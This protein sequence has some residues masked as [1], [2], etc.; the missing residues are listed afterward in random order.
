VNKK[1][2]MENIKKE[3]YLGEEKKKE[4][5][6]IFQKLRKRGLA[7]TLTGLLM[8]GG[9]AA[10]SVEAMMGQLKTDGIVE[11]IGD[12]EKQ[13]KKEIV[14]LKTQENIFKEQ[15]P[16]KTVDKLNYIIEKVGSY[17]AGQLGCSWGDICDF[18]NRPEKK[19][20]LIENLN[21][22]SEIKKDI[23]EPVIMDSL[24][25]IGLEPKAVQK[26]LKTLP[27][28]WREEV[29]LITYLNKPT[30]VVANEITGE[31]DKLVAHHQS[32]GK[33]ALSEIYFFPGA[34]ED[35]SANQGK[36]ECLLQVLIYEY[37]HVNNWRNRADLTLG[38]RISLFYEVIKR[39]ESP[40][41]FKYEMVEKI[42]CKDK[43]KELARKAIEYW[44][45]ISWFSIMRIKPTKENPHTQPPVADLRLV[46][47]YLKMTDPDFDI[48]KMAKKR[49]KLLKRVQEEREAAKPLTSPVS[50]LK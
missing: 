18:D 2:F 12:S 32:K 5:K 11:K 24:K 31:K 28:S 36:P 26:F 46:Y 38:Q 4:K 6:S 13:P 40:D 8:A 22:K 44:A 45:A 27:E 21:Q 49:L 16:E 34:K 47:N 41:R 30:E 23:K 50:L 17:T 3:F 25:Q 19:R 29:A 14:D 10:K 37:S 42:R 33:E 15:T 43:K 9:P 35:Q 1:L 7:M 20:E 48:L 39:V